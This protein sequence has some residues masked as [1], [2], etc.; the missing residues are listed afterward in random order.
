M[1]A[2]EKLVEYI[3][4]NRRAVGS[5]LLIAAYNRIIGCVEFIVVIYEIMRAVIRIFL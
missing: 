1:K 3:F 2:Q 5:S 4:T